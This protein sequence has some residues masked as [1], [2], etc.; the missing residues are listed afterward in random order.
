MQ[1]TMLKAVILNFDVD[2]VTFKT[3]IYRAV[4]N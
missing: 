1:K 4:E 3:N 2:E